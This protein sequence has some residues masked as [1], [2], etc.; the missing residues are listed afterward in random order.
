M[1]GAPVHRILRNPNYV[2]SIYNRVTNRPSPYE[3][4][5]TVLDD[6]VNNRKL[7]LIGTTNSS[8]LLA[9][10]T[11]EL[12]KDVKPDTLFVQAN[13]KWWNLVKGLKKIN[14]QSDLNEHNT[15][16][17]SANDWSL[18]NNPRGI[19]FKLRFYPWIATM[20][21]LFRLPKDFHPFTPGLET[22][23]AIEEAVKAKSEILFGGLEIDPETLQALRIEKRMDLIPLL[24]RAGISL[25]NKLWK[26]EHQDI[27]RL[28]KTQGGE[29]FAELLDKHRVSWFIK[30]F[31]K[32]APLQKKIFIDQ[33]DA[34]IFHTLYR[35]KGK[36][37]VAVVNQWHTLG[38]EAHWR[39][40]TGTEIQAEPINPVCDFNIESYME[41][42]LINDKLREIISHT[43]HS[44]PATWQSYI[45]QYHKETQEA[46]RNRHVHFLSYEDPDIH[47]GLFGHHGGEGSDF[48]VHPTQYREKPEYIEYRIGWGGLVE[49]GEKL[50]ELEDKG[51]GHH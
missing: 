9:K 26:T 27:F 28:L 40:S 17:R 11:Q 38:I 21:S 4:T 5:L 37:I 31:E 3:S 46:H 19:I 30:L 20:L 15:V 34:D 8:T 25:H 10:R 42:E 18:E 39:H 44:E 1:I 33:K 16:L 48:N 49:S 23:W 41:T 14:S 6:P 43:T 2:S 24:Y 13:F 7:Y 36:N 29:N 12:V 22:K 45:T 51:K 32:Y 47:H 35:A 50:K